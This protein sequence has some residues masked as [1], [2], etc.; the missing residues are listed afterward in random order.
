MLRPLDTST[1]ERKS[2]G[3]LWRFRLDPQGVGRLERWFAR[4]LEES[5]AMAVPASFNDIGCDPEQREFAG[6]VW[7]QTTAWIPR[8][9]RGRRIV[10]YFESA[11]GLRRRRGVRPHRT[12]AGSDRR[13]CRRLV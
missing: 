11:N 8:G 2:L 7:Y 3:G 4:P 12:G 13:R 5:R 9:W 10:V 1:R 6:D